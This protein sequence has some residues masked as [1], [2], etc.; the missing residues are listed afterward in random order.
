MHG[1][2]GHGCGQ[3]RWRRSRCG[4]GGCL[5]VWLPCV[6]VPLP[7]MPYADPGCCHCRHDLVMDPLLV[8]V[9][10]SPSALE[11]RLLVPAAAR[12]T[13]SAAQGPQTRH[14]PSRLT[15]SAAHRTPHLVTGNLPNALST[16]TD[17]P[18]PHRH[19]RGSP[20]WPRWPAPPP[21]QPCTA[22]SRPP[23]EAPSPS[24]HQAPPPPLRLRG[25]GQ[26]EAHPRPRPSLLAPPICLAPVMS[27]CHP[28]PPGR[29]HP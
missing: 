18:P 11:V 28:P 23:P 10:P 26:H 19:R 9:F 25:P 22:P 17:P 3:R 1:G 15:L 24:A 20:L 5:G 8:Q 16:R 13:L 2:G 7:G 21:P 6:A 29:G 12:L 27:R 14:S 4:G